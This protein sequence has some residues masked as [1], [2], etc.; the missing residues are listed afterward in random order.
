LLI[1]LGSVIFIIPD[2]LEFRTNCITYLKNEKKRKKKKINEVI[3]DEGMKKEKYNLNNLIEK[4]WTETVSFKP[5]NLLPGISKEN[6]DYNLKQIII[7]IKMILSNAFL[8]F[9]YKRERVLIY[10]LDYDKDINMNNSE[11]L[12]NIFA[13]PKVRYKIYD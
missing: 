2:Y 13:I 3:D 7:S 11:I 6:I 8:H 10:F 9:A 12:N 1:F 4:N 5:K